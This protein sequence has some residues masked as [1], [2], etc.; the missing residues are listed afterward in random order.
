MNLRRAS[1]RSLC[2]AAGP[3]SLMWLLCA[4]A[5]AQATGSRAKDTTS[6][7]ADSSTRAS[8]SGLIPAGYGTLRQDD[9]A[10]QVQT[11]GLL[12]KVMPLEESV[13]RTLSP[14]SYRS[15][16]GIRESKA[17][18]LDSVSS[19][20]GLP[21]VQPWLVTFF[22]AEVGEARFDAGD[23]LIRSGGRD[24]RP[25]RIL[26]LKVGFGDGRLAQHS[27][28]GAVY[29]F[30]PAID[31][32]QPITI[33]AGTQSSSIWADIVQRIEVER[34]LIWSRAGATKPH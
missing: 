20:T 10:V 12:V 3:L 6:T 7:R 32:T 30:D 25:L 5:G 19:R 1:R 13:I 16:N 17:K 23:V 26:P 24:F 21:P 34:S 22:N 2:L 15:L 11:L 18:Q 27:Q 33:T 9:I 8:R 14:D 4:T 28:Q 31:L 29:A